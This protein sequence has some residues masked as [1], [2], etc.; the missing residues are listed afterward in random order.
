MVYK[1]RS[2]VKR[3]Y[4]RKS[5]AARKVSA[6]V[7][8]FVKQKLNFLSRR[9]MH[10][11]AENKTPAP[12]TR[13]DNPLQPMSSTSWGTIISLADVFNISQG[14]G[15]GNRIGNQ[16]KPM[17]WSFRGF[18]HNNSVSCVPYV[19]KMFILKS[20]Q[21]YASPDTITTAA[22]TDFL[23]NG[24]ASAA[25]SVSYNDLLR[26]VNKEKYTVYTTRTFKCS[27]ASVGT[28]PNF[29]T[30]NDFKMVCPFKINL[31]K[32]QK[33]IIKYNDNTAT[34]T[35]QGL[36]AVFCMAPA[37]GTVPTLPLTGQPQISSDII[38]EYEDF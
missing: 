18:I 35:N 28:A 23:Q 27:P 33:H 37:D 10:R 24:S 22:P 25:P 11:Y 30:N 29:G 20:T 14:T 1:K 5:R 8:K 21:S 7:K 6:P 32:Y 9:V 12:V 17:K 2:P 26:D 13:L 38:A 4:N 16:L 34:P 36:Y 15:Q 3:S 19:I 31:L